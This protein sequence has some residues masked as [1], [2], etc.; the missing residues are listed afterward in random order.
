MLRSNT[1][2]HDCSLLRDIA[3]VFKH[4][5]IDRKSATIK[6]SKAVVTVS[7]GYGELGYG[8]GKFDGTEQIIVELP[9][10]DKRALS[11]ILQNVVDAWRRLLVLSL[12]PVSEF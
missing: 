2:C 9:N 10:G 6:H 4:S 12:P 1:M 5:S 11:S 7:T 8:E 3:D